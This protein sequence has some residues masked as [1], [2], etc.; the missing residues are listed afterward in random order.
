MRP[1]LRLRTPFG[2]MRVVLDE[3]ATDSYGP[4]AQAQAAFKYDLDTGI[5]C[6]T[7]GR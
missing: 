6:V 4:P 2:D 5:T 7:C 1:P 3:R